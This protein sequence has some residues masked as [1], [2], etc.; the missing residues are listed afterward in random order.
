M[1]GDFGDNSVPVPQCY[2]HEWGGV[3][4]RVGIRVGESGLHW[5]P[6]GP[7]VKLLSNNQ[8]LN[9]LLGLFLY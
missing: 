5:Y 9:G 4:V 8:L 7:D 6:G 2:M 1:V 3:G